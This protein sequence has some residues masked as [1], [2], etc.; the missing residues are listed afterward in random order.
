MLPTLVT[1]ALLQDGN[2]FLVTRRPPRS[3][4]AGLWE[5]PGGKLE[6]HESPEDALVR[7][8]QEDLG[9]EVRVDEVFDVLYHR[10]PSGAIL[11]LVYRCTWL[12]GRL[13]HLGVAEHRWA[14]PEEME[15]LALLPADAPLVAKLRH[16]A[17]P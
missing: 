7:E 16:H 14:T 6:P 15:Q 1:A 3:R 12:S 9:I 10:Y 11:L 8:L 2:R 13:Q 4:H 17:G 5:F